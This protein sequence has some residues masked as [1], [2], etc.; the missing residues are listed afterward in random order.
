MECYEI[1]SLILEPPHV[2]TENRMDTRLKPLWVHRPDPVPAI[3]P[4]P[5][6][7]RTPTNCSRQPHAFSMFGTSWGCIWLTRSRG[8]FPWELLDI[9]MN[10]DSESNR[11]VE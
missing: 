1:Y 11:F 5:R 10:P 2:K 3:Y 7:E 9:F 4:S 6:G 8:S